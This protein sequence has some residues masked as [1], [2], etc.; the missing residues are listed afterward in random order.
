M[1]LIN[2]LLIIYEIILMI[3]SKTGKNYY[4]FKLPIIYTLFDIILTFILF[5]EITLH[6]FVIYKCKICEYV[7]YN[8]DH[9]IDITVFFLSLFLCVIYIGDIFGISDMDNIGF[10]IIRIIRD[11][12]RFVR[13]FIFAKFLYD[14]IVEWKKPKKNRNIFN[15]YGTHSTESS[16]CSSGWEQRMKTEDQTQFVCV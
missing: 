10:L 4:N 15:I 13:C 3:N 5:I 16:S 12:M 8:Y 2:T 11:I 9:K 14:S 1:V 6:L 7:K